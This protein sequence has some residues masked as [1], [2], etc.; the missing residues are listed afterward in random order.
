MAKLKVYT[1]ISTRRE[2]DKEKMDSKRP[3]VVQARYIAAVSSKKEFV[4]LLGGTMYFVNN[5]GHKT[6]N[7]DDIKKAMANPHKLIFNGSI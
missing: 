1:I 4:E 7:S 2:E 5:Y 3:W 6:H